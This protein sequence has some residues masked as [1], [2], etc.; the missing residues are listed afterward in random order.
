MDPHQ[1]N[2]APDE[3]PGDTTGPGP[4]ASP[5]ARSLNARVGAVAKNVAS[6]YLTLFV[7]AVLGL[8]VTPILLRHLGAS[9]FGTWSLV[10]ATGGYLGLLELGLGTA[11]TTRVAALETQGPQVLGRVVSTALT[12]FA[13]VAA[14]RA[15]AHGAAEHLLPRPL[16]RGATSGHASSSCLPAHRQLAMHAGRDR[17]V[18]G[19][20]D[21]DRQDVPRQSQRVWHFGG[22]LA[23]PSRGG[24]RGGTADPTR[25]HSTR[26]GPTDTRRIPVDGQPPPPRSDAE[27]TK[28]RPRDRAISAGAGL[29]Q[30]CERLRRRA[31]L[32]IGPRLGRT[33]LEPDGGRRIRSG[34][35][36]LKFHVTAD[37]RCGRS[38][39]AVTCVRCRQ[40]D[41]RAAVRSLLPCPQSDARACRSR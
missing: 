30:F 12:M 28:L 14:V 35:T 31:R 37:V 10:L 25:C 17:R 11:T 21:R 18:L 3:A 7:G 2:L 8:V 34:T 33:P 20:P 29:A 23:G 15:P 39:R 36:R 27:P 5:P 32:R 41:R 19:V 13:G 24:Y 16:Q 9:G 1:P 38:K 22:R 6:G 40:Y 4:S 26:G